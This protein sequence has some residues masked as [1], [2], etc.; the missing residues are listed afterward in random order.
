[1]AWALE[2][3]PAQAFESSPLRTPSPLTFHSQTA[4]LRL[5]TR[6]TGRLRVVPVGVQTAMRFEDGGEGISCQ[7]VFRC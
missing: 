2:S 6:L 4:V 5:P 1:M 7:R 3:C